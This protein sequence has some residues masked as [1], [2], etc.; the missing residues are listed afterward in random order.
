MIPRMAIATMVRNEECY[1]LEW[2][3]FHMVQGVQHFRIY[4]NNSDDLTAP[5]LHALMPAVPMQYLTV[6]E[7]FSDPIHRRTYL[8]ALHALSGKFDWVGLMDMDEFAHSVA[9]GGL[10]AAFAQFGSDV[11][12]VAMNQSVFGSSGELTHRPDIVTARMIRRAEDNY[13]EHLWFKSFARPT[14]VIEVEGSHSVKLQS[15]R[16]AHGDGSAPVRDQSH[17]GVANRVAMGSLRFHHYSVKS[18][19]EYRAKQRRWNYEPGATGVA[20]VYDDNYQDKREPYTNAVEDLTLYNR[21]EHTR[22]VM[23][24]L[25]AQMRD[26]GPAI[27]DMLHRNY[28]FLNS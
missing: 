2:I 27:L 22:D 21:A 18:R 3:A 25:I 17:P 23:R 14:S 7:P 24:M 1:L 13:G 19:E 5:L 28:A 15:G 26:P 9:P 12:A 8:N 6:A 20:G 4:D 16:Y 11:G 10:P